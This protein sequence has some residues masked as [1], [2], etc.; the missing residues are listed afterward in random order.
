MSI[1][2]NKRWDDLLRERAQKRR[3]PYT[4]DAA[5]AHHL[6]QASKLARTAGNET[7]AKLYHIDA[8]HHWRRAVA[9]FKSEH[10]LTDPTSHA[11]STS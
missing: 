2:K 4:V 1:P 11:R 10:R 7:W 6:M 8:R 3:I 9:S 5:L